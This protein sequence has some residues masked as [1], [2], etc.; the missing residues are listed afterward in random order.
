MTAIAIGNEA[1]AVGPKVILKLG[2]DLYAVAGKEGGIEYDCLHPTGKETDL[3]IIDFAKIGD[4]AAG[5]G[6]KHRYFGK[7]E[8]T[9]YAGNAADYPGE[10]AHAGRSARSTIDGVRLKEYTCADNTSD[11]DG[12][13][14]HYAQI[15]SETLLTVHCKL[16]PSL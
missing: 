12:H 11:N 13:C 4:H 8:R 2:T 15:L 3:I 9:E 1:F 5:L 16:N 6:D 14:G 10:H 7:G